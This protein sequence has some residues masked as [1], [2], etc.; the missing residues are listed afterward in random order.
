MLA[1]SGK[2]GNDNTI[3]R[4]IVGSHCLQKGEVKL[5]I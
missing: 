5:E 3:K 2:V 1:K 4:S